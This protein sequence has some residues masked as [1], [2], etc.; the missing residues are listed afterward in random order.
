[1]K[2]IDDIEAMTDADRLAHLLQWADQAFP[3]ATD[4]A[5]ANAIGYQRRSWAKWK[6]NPETIPSVVLIAMQEMAFRED[7]ERMVL[8]SM[9]EIADQMAAMAQNM[10]DLARLLRP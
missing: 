3:R 8:R 1:M 4:E 6:S 7:R 9:N 10:A 5:K 2:T